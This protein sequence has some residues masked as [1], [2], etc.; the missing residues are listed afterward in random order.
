R[1]LDELPW[2]SD[3]E[4]LEQITMVLLLVNLSRPGQVAALS[5]LIG[6]MDTQE[7]APPILCLP[8]A[9][10]DCEIE[11]AEQQAL[12]EAL[13]ELG[14]DDVLEGQPAGLGLILAAK[15]AVE[16]SIHRVER[17]TAQANESASAV[18]YL[19]KLKAALR[20]TLWEYLPQELSSPLPPVDHSIALS[21]GVHIAGWTLGRRLSSGSIFGAVYEVHPPP[22]VPGS[23]QAMK[24][25]PKSVVTSFNE[26]NRVKRMLRVLEVLR[27]ENWRHPGI[28]MMRSLFHTTT[29]LFIRMDLG[30]PE[31]LYHRLGLRDRGADRSILTSPLLSS[32]VRQVADCI[33]HLHLGPKICHRDIKPENFT[34]AQPDAHSIM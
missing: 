3:A 25:I 10:D 34:V 26:L 17:V 9:S 7:L 1:D 27:S 2:I 33:A 23:T 18:A 6:H 24:V 28:V 29:H 16:R 21:N 11:E 15:A 4:A 5:V 31:T 19:A 13:L 20:T 32:I 8:I 12:T 14:A 30:A 22:G